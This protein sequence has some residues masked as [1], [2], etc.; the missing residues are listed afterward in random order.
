MAQ[1]RTPI[2]QATQPRLDRTGAAG[3][4]GDPQAHNGPQGRGD[5]SRDEIGVGE[6]WA[7]GAVHR[8]RL[9]VRTLVT[10]R[11]LV[12]AG[13]VALLLL[14]MVLRFDIPYPLCFAVVGAG[15]WVNL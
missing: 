7:E 15:A 2:A 10:L 1:T 4:Q 8:G 12:V 5:L 13:E 14:V 3:A 11:W 6:D 9:R